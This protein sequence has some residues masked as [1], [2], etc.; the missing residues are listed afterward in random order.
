LT[1]GCK[2]D[3]HKISLHI[4]GVLMPPVERTLRIYLCLSSTHFLHSTCHNIDI[5]YITEL[6]SLLPVDRKSRPLLLVIMPQLFSLCY[7][8]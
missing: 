7:R 8:P 2:K 5:Y 3:G 6:A 1:K 4:V